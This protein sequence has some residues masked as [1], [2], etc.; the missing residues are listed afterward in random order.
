MRSPKQPVQ[1]GNP[2][3]LP[4]PELRLQNEAFRE[5]RP[6]VTRV[7][8]VL[9]SG[10]GLLV[11]AG[12][13]YL[14]TAPAAAVGGSC[15]DY[16]SRYSRT[17]LDQYAARSTCSSLEGDSKARAVLVRDGGPDYY[18]DWFTRLDTSYYTKKYTCYI[19]CHSDTQIRKK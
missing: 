15:R 10:I 9:A 12:G 3:E 13:A 18:S 2:V 7:K 5:V 11:V 14:N 6:D 16:L 8:K 4:N 17:G 19:D 1:S